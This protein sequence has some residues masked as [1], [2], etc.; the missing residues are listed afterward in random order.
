MKDETLRVNETAVISS[1]DFIER[2][3][4]LYVGV[5]ESYKQACRL[6]SAFDREVSAVYHEIEKTRFDV[7]RGYYLAKKLQ[8]VLHRRRAVKSEV[9]R[10]Q[11]IYCFLRD[12]FKNVES[13]YKERSKKDDEVRT[14][15]NATLTID[16]VIT[17]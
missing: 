6:L 11:P 3:R 2:L 5:E 4:E 9:V 1:A 8:N 12:N 7:V 17:K 10:L 13:V 15:L 14:S 16:D